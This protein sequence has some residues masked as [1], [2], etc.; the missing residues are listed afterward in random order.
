ML[1]IRGLPARRR[2]VGIGIRQLR[3]V[4]VG[5]PA[6]QLGQPGRRPPEGAFILD[7]ACLISGR[8]GP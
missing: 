5:L 2:A 8:P 1:P 6:E 7:V 3:L 4:L